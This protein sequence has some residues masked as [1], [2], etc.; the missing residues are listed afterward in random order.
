MIVRMNDTS[1]YYIGL[2]YDIRV[3]SSKQQKALILRSLIT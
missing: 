2:Y 3:Q 1:V